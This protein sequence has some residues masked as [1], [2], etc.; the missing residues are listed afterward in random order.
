V[1]ASSESDCGGASSWRL[2]PVRLESVRNMGSDCKKARHW[3][4]ISGKDSSSAFEYR[5]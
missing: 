1:S 4:R 3:R 5:L 2:R